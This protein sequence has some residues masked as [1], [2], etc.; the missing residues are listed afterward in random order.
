M[1]KS[2]ENQL[3]IRLI[4]LFTLTGASSRI[5]YFI[6]NILVHDLGFSINKANLV[7]TLGGLVCT[8]ISIPIVGILCDKFKIH[9]QIISL[10]AFL[11][12]LFCFFVYPHFKSYTMILGIFGIS[13]GLFYGYRD[14]IDIYTSIVTDD[15]NGGFLK[16]RAWYYIGFAFSS[17][18]GANLSFLA[19]PNIY[20]FYGF[21]LLILSL[22]SILFLNNIDVEK[23][24]VEE[25][26]F[27]YSYKELKKNKEFVITTLIGFIIGGIAVS[28]PI[29]IGYFIDNLSSRH[30]KGFNR[31]LT[32]LFTG[33]TYIA[34]FIYLYLFYYLESKFSI[35]KIA[36]FEICGIIIATII[37]I[38]FTN[39]WSD[40]VLLILFYGSIEPLFI[41]L[42]F[43]ML[44]KHTDP[45]I[46]GF[47]IGVYNMLGMG[48]G[49]VIFTIVSGMFS[50]MK[51]SYGFVFYT[52]T[53]IVSLPLIALKKD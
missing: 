31:S 18:I 7:T 49:G 47:S 9:K 28:Y 45:T 13:W 32:G 29:E 51:P 24:E 26:E 23:K 37:I 34:S 44:A 1:F 8:F 3:S 25:Q 30:I 43:S 21:I 42:G 16:V 20:Y 14:C 4:I 27:S 36:L 22:Y 33:G 15:S 52:A 11:L 48:F 41:F 19:F 39:A 35:K 6:P 5:P 12:A 40:M 10:L 38:T 50:Q 53:L 17:L 46:R 2:K